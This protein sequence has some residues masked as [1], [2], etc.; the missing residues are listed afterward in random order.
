VDFSV[1]A[2][3]CK[4]CY[5]KQ[6]CGGSWAGRELFG[7][8]TASDD[9]MDVTACGVCCVPTPPP[10]PTQEDEDACSD[11]GSRDKPGSALGRAVPDGS[12]LFPDIFRTDHLL[13]YERFKAYQDYILGK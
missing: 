8:G 11:Y 10:A 9:C 6:A 2:V 13:F 7:N 1:F 5:G 12:V 3:R 4:I